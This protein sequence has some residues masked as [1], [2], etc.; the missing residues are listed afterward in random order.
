MPPV[1]FLELLRTTAI[2]CGNEP[3]VVD[4]LD[5]LIG[6]TT[7]D[8]RDRLIEK[9]E[10]LDE[11]NTGLLKDLE[12]LRAAAARVCWFDWSGNDN[13]AVVAIEALRELIKE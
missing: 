7:L 11:D 12:R 9:I 1:E 6:L 2:S 13:D 4:K 3:V 5:E 8:D 10:Q